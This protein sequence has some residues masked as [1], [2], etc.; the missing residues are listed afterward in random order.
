MGAVA[1]E[2]QRDHAS[3][4][5]GRE[6]P[7]QRSHGTTGHLRLPREAPARPPSRVRVLGVLGVLGQQARQPCDFALE[8]VKS[9]S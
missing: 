1:P 6:L 8:R 3:N 7:A 4:P 5:T 2:N 9:L